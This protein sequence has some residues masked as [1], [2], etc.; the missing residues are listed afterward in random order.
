MVALYKAK[1]GIWNDNRPKIIAVNSIND[2]ENAAN[3]V[4]NSNFFDV[5]QHKT[6]HNKK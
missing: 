2:K 5:F 4:Y 6:Q 3:K 1:N